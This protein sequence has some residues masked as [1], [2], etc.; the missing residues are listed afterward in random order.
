[1]FRGGRLRAMCLDQRDKLAK[2]TKLQLKL[3]TVDHGFQGGLQ[4]VITNILDNQQCHIQHDNHK[5]D[6]QQFVHDFRPSVVLVRH[7]AE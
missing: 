4:R 6:R 2:D 1:M 5:V 3:D 7:E